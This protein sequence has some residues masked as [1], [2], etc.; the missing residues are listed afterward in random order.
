MKL[1]RTTIL[2]ITCTT[3]TVLL[4]G[5][6]F[7]F[8]SVIRNK[9]I[10]TEFVNKTLEDRVKEKKQGS[11]L[12]KVINEANN[13]NKQINSYFVNTNSIDSF[14]SDLEKKSMEFGTHAE[15]QSVEFSKDNKKAITIV[16]L[17]EGNFSSVVKVV[18]MIEYMPYAININSF[19]LSANT[20]QKDSKQAFYPWTVTVS[21]NIFTF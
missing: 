21:F 11:S 3:I 14:V 18:K 15:V 5:F 6:T 1:S 16:L 4:V 2:L 17:A 8:F 19:N 9:N 20:S 7:F 13:Q 10:H 12:I